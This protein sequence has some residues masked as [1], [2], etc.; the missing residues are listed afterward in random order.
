M[1]TVQIAGKSGTAEIGFVDRW[2]SWFTA[3]APY[4][5]VNPDEQIV[6]TVIIEESTYQIW[7]AAAVSAIIFQGYFAHQD[8][9]TAIRSLGFQHLLPNAEARN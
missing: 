8:Y 5:S 6:V 9:E 1:R 4:N 2:H 3:Y 7:M